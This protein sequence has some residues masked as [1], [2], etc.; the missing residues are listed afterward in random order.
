MHKEGFLNNADGALISK[1]VDAASDSGIPILEQ[2]AK[3]LKGLT[4]IAGGVKQDRF[5]ERRQ[6]VYDLFDAAKYQRGF[7]KQFNIL[8]EQIP[9]R[10]QDNYAPE[11]E[12]LRKFTVH[13]LN[14]NNP[15]LG[16]FYNLVWP[17]WIM[18]NAG[19]VKPEGIDYAKYL[20]DKY[21]PGTY[22]GQE[23]I[24]NNART[25]PGVYSDK[26]DLTKSP[27]AVG[28]AGGSSVGNAISLA[29]TNSIWLVVALILIVAGTWWANRK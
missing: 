4:S 6:R 8:A 14:Y 23:P 28:T 19:Q 7:S 1:G 22:K 10:K 18:A 2:A 5:L 16:D 26:P 20:V 27:L 15:G 9:N 21:P 25:T 17:A 11:Y 13:V 29:G 24:P 12:R 3:V